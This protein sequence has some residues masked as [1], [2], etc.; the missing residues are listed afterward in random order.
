MFEC[1]CVDVQKR[2]TSRRRQTLPRCVDFTSGIAGMVS[3]FEVPT[4]THTHP[5]AHMVSHLHLHMTQ[6][7][8]ITL[9]CECTSPLRFV[10]N[11]RNMSLATA[12][13]CTKHTRVSG[14][15]Q[16]SVGCESNLRFYSSRPCSRPSPPPPQALPLQRLLLDAPPLQCSFALWCLQIVTHSLTHTQS[17]NTPRCVGRNVAQQSRCQLSQ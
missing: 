15:W 4:H 6:A 16:G 12:N 11:E 5:P 8:V 10:N 7:S 17:D 3:V 13:V 14:E 1:V 9:S 2:T